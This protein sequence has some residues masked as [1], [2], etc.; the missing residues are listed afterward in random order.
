MRFRGVYLLGNRD[1]GLYKIG[2]SRDIVSRLETLRAQAPF[3]LEWLDMWQMSER[4]MSREETFLHEKFRAKCERG[5][6]FRLS[7]AELEDLRGYRAV[8]MDSEKAKRAANIADRFGR[9]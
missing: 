1:F 8:D 9:R 6:W 5:E 7:A 4:E 2:K 3:S